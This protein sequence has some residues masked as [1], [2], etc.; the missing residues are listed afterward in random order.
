VGGTSVV[1]ASGYHR[2]W[3]ALLELIQGGR[4][5]PR[6]ALVLGGTDVVVASGDHRVWV[7]LL[8]LIQGR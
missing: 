2:V 7:A 8:E 5:G 6:R 1:V 3:V 4:G